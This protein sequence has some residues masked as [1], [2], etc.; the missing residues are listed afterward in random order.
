MVGRPPLPPSE[1]R[2]KKLQVPLTEAE[3]KAMKTAAKRAAKPTAEWLRDLGLAALRAQKG[4]Q[5]GA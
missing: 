3:E 2:S 1:R 4:K 5:H